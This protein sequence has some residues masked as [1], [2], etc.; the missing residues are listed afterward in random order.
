MRSRAWKLQI[1][2]SYVQLER[3]GDRE[4]YGAECVALGCN[5]PMAH[6]VRQERAGEFGCADQQA[7]TDREERVGAF[8]CA[9]QQ[10]QT[11]RDE[12][13]GDLGCIDQ[14]A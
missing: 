12:R 14:Q 3:S 1:R 11:N 6:M 5:D 4:C 10:A 8:G 2:S 13:T 7:Q 9:D